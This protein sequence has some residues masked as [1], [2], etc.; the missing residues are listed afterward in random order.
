MIILFLFHAFHLL[1]YIYLDME[2][3]INVLP[4]DIEAR[5]ARDTMF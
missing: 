3:V 5:P 2:K 4:W 1:L